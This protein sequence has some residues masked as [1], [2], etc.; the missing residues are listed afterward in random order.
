MGWIAKIFGLAVVVVTFALAQPATAPAQTLLDQYRKDGVIAERYDGY[1]ELRG[2]GAP[3]GAVSLVRDVNEQRRE[4]Y[5]KRAREENVP[6][7]EV[8]KLFAKKLA[9][10]G[11]PAGT[12]FKLPDGSYKRK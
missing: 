7:E 8:G 5:E 6:V 11:A 9:E 1:L 10:Q 2:A 12:Y 3:A 4:V